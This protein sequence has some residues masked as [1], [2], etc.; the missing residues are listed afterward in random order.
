MVKPTIGIIGGGQLGSM[1]AIAA[2]K[3]EINTVIFCDDADAPAGSTDIVAAA[4]LMLLQIMACKLMSLN[5][6]GKLPA[7]PQAIQLLLCIQGF[8]QATALTL[9]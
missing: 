7:E 3:I 5:M 6:A 2:K 9:T 8:L 4:L 1:L